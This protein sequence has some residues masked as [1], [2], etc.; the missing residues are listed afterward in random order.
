MCVLYTVNPKFKSRTVHPRIRKF[1][2]C[3]VIYPSTVDSWRGVSSS[4]FV[5]IGCRDVS[6]LSDITGLDETLLLVPKKVF[7]KIKR[8]SAYS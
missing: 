6:H 4:V 1:F 7:N 2:S 3:S 8:D 5:D